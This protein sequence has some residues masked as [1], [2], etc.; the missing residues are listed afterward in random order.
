MFKILIAD[1]NSIDLQI[2]TLTLQ[3]EAYQLFSAQNGKDAL[4]LAQQVKPDLILLDVKMPGIGGFE[5]CQKLKASKA[6]MNISIIFLSALDE[7]VNK[8]QGL[9]IGGEDYITK[10]FSPEEVSARVRVHLALCAK[11]KELEQLREQDQQYF[12]RINAIRDGILEQMEHDVKSPLASIK[13]STHLINRHTRDQDSR[14]EGYTER[15]NQA[16]DETLHV[17]EH[18]LEI[19]KL[20][21]GRSTRM[22]PVAIESFIQR[23]IIAYQ[24]LAE[25][26]DIQF[27]IHFETHPGAMAYFDPDQMQRVISNLL[28]NALKYTATKGT[29]SLTVRLENQTLHLAV[30]DTGRGI[31]EGDIPKIFDRLYRVPLDDEQ[32]EGTGLGLYIVKSIVEQHGGVIE[33]Q[34]QVHKGSTFVVSIPQDQLASV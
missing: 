24:A 25:I 34:S 28:S 16:V 11:R 4:R 15:I 18:L 13:V 33:V 29:V 20:E 22:K 27:L 5:V 23:V 31:S 30:S 26:K 1:D 32:I 21:T 10:P 8:L 7:Q 2:L 17:M 6:T 19:A 14:I 3:N 12:A 9:N